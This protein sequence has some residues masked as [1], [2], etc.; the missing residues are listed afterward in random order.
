MTLRDALN[1]L[2]E[3][4]GAFDER[5]INLVMPGLD[6]LRDMQQ[7][8]KRLHTAPPAELAGM[9]VLRMRD[10]LAGTVSIPGFG[11]VGKTPIAGSDVLYFELADGTSFIIRPSGTE[12]K[13]KIYLLARG[14]T[15]AECAARI[16]HY[17]GWTDGLRKR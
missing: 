17:A 3:V 8:M 9:Q 12:P 4:Y 10:Y 1:A 2:Y 13:I 16:A 6:G 7:L 15:R 5:T 14:G 11:P